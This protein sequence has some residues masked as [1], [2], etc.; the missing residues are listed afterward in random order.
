MLPPS[1]RN[2]RYY[3]SNVYG[4][5]GRSWEQDLEEAKAQKA[6]GP[7]HGRLHVASEP[8]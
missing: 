4:G 7:A 5:G 3:S 2:E 6:P 8:T 1:V